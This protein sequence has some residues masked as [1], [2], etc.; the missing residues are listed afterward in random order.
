MNRLKVNHQF[1]YNQYGMANFLIE[2]STLILIY[3]HTFIQ[4][5][6]P[7]DAMTN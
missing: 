1:H 4:F 6:I 5:R 3:L 2:M 7:G